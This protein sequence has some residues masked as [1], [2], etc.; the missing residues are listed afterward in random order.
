M[1][2]LSLQLNRLEKLEQYANVEKI[3]DLNIEKDYSST[4]ADRIDDRGNPV[5]Y[6]PSTT[7]IL[8]HESRSRVKFI[9][10]PFGSGK[11][12]MCCHEIIYRSCDMPPCHDGVRRSRWA[13][14]RNTAGKLETTTL[15]TWLQWFSHL[16]LV[17]RN[18]KPILKYLYRF[19]DG[20]GPVEIELLFLGL[21]REDQ[22]DMLESLELTGA[23]FNELP[24][25]AQGIFSHMISR[26]ERYPSK[27]QISKPYY[28]CILADANPPDTD[29]WLYRL[30]EEEKPDNSTMFNQP[31]GLIKD[32]KTNKWIDNTKADNIK[33]LPEKYYY[34][35]AAQNRFSEEYI[36]V[37]CRGEW[38]IVVKGKHVFEEYNDDLHSVLDVIPLE[39]ETIYLAWDFGLTPA[40]LIMQFRDDGQLRCLKEFTTE[41]MFIRELAKDIVSPFINKNFKG[42]TIISVGDPS[43]D[44]G[45]GSSEMAVSAL[46][47]L[48]EEGIDTKRARSNNLL[49]RLSAVKYYL[50]RLIAGESAILISRTGCPMLRK[51][52]NGHYYYKRVRVIG[53]ES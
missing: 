50:T 28:A 12:V 47:I 26:I 24:H 1:A 31:P 18:K 17:S 33:N 53:E 15:A 13:I 5:E 36:K 16:P 4:V 11:S 39:N 10:G 29:H 34:N 49:P 19:D 35:I 52:M 8:F 45:G 21:D 25:I 48:R 22:R 23:Y 14:V 20:K 42:Y 6:I 9:K 38:G 40:C 43:G 27:N 30:F 7:G 44:A 3:I 32:P 46:E 2:R 51:S 41:R 37:Y